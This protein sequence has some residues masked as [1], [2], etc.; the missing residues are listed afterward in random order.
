MISQ[1]PGDGC[2][3]QNISGAGDGG[4]YRYEQAIVALSDCS[5]C[6]QRG[7]RE[8]VFLAACGAGLLLDVACAATRGGQRGTARNCYQARKH[9]RES[10][11]AARHGG[12]LL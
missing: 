2:R 11:F 6:I 8:D 5:W 3:E 1:H 4:T 9:G 12:C 10:R 7:G